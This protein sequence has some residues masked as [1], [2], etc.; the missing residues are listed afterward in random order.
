M[1][2]RVARG[3]FVGTGRRYMTMHIDPAAHRARAQ[4][5]PPR[6]FCYANRVVCDVL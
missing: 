5:W 3:D 2:E 6:G 1:D 4:M